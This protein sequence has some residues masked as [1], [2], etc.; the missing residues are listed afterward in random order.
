MK[1]DR[2]FVSSAFV[3]E[4]YLVT[5]CT[6]AAKQRTVLYQNINRSATVR[7]LSCRLAYG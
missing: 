3:E 4:Y 6:A 5:R 7:K 2:S 1:F